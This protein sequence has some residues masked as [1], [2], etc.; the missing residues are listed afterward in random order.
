MSTAHI[1]AELIAAFLGEDEPCYGQC[2]CAAVLGIRTEVASMSEPC[3]TEY[4]LCP[5]LRGQSGLGRLMRSKSVRDSHHH[6]W[7]ERPTVPA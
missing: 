6:A 7:A 5:R 1:H 3:T 4:A 2:Q